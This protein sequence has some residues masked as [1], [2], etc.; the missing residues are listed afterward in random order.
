[1]KK[2]IFFWMLI[3]AGNILNA[4]HAQPKNLR[5]AIVAGDSDAVLDFIVDDANVNDGDPL[6]LAAKELVD[7][8]TSIK[9][10]KTTDLFPL[11]ERIFIVELLKKAHAKQT[12]SYKDYWQKFTDI[13]Q[14]TND[15]NKAYLEIVD[16]I[17]QNIKNGRYD[18]KLLDAAQ[19]GNLKIV[20]AKLLLG[21]N[22]D[23]QSQGEKL[24]ALM[25]AVLNNDAPMVGYLINKGA[26]VNIKNFYNKTALLLALRATKPNSQIVYYILGTD[27]KKSVDINY[28]PEGTLPP[29]ILAVKSDLKGTTNLTKRLLQE[30]KIDLHIKGDGKTALEHVQSYSDFLKT[31]KDL[32][33]TKPGDELAFLMLLANAEKIGNMLRLAAASAK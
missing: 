3:F 29:L 2:I 7:T 8:A 12:D 31:H 13:T 21:A 15:I 30:P 11:T 23:A 20:K 26:N 1:M 25:F 18:D 33:V 6:A 24:T 5:D 28:A 19:R 27:P 9:T 16:D 4:S 22:I 32:I 10:K 17:E 14:S